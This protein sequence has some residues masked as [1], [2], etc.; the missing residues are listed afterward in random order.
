V[1]YPFIATLQSLP[2]SG[3]YEGECLYSVKWGEDGKVIDAWENYEESYMILEELFPK[4]K[5]IFIMCG[6]GGYAGM[7]KELLIFLGWDPDKL[8]NIG[9]NWS[10]TGENSLELVVY[11]DEYSGENIY[12]T[13]RADY[14]YIDFTRLHGEE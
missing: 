1:P 3:A 2:V 13:W 4:D 11:S 10:Y 14:A 12:A 6:G 8:Y 5:A 7:M 9:G